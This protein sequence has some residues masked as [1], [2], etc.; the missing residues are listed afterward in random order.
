MGCSALFARIHGKFKFKPFPANPI[1]LIRDLSLRALLR[2]FSTL[3]LPMPYLAQIFGPDYDWRIITISTIINP[4]PVKSDKI[5]ILKDSR[6][7]RALFEAPLILY[8]P[9]LE[10]ARSE[11]SP[12]AL[13]TGR[14]MEEARLLKTE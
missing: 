13:F 3:Q 11:C 14:V 8:R 5:V 10:P 7:G 12:G 9:S 1:R 4:K 2:Y 6:V